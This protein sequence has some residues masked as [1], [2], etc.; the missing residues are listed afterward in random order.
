VSDP[1]KVI[2]ALASEVLALG[3]EIRYGS[4]VEV[5]SERALSLNGEILSAK[6]FVNAAGSQSDRIAHKFDLGLDY[7]MI[8]FMGVYRAV[9][10]DQ[11]PLQRLVYPVPHLSV[12][13]RS[14]FLLLE[15]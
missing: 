6:H 10:A 12:R 15:M 8:P 3:G 11:L 14:W 13:H 1:A 9:R 2:Q 4:V 5:D 7:S